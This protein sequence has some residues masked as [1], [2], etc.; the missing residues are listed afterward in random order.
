MIIFHLCGFV[1]MIFRH[2][3]LCGSHGAKLRFFFFWL[4]LCNHGQV[5]DEIDIV[6]L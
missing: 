1:S 2:Q 4:H 6:D 5:H 3:L